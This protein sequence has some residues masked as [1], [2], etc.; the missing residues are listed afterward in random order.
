MFFCHRLPERSFFFK[1]KQFPICARCTGILIGYIIGILYIFFNKNLHII[2][3]LSFMIPLLIDGTG[4]YIGY[5]KST[6]IR[7]LI[8]GILAGISTICL[9]RLACI[10]GLQ[11]GY[12]LHSYIT[13][14]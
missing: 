13:I 7:R 14:K 1:G 9:F 3:E 12:W 5:F 4:Q 10:W 11:S 8:T 6:N 2:I